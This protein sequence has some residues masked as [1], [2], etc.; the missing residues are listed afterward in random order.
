VSDSVIAVLEW[1]RGSMRVCVCVH[2]HNRVRVRVCE[3]E[4]GDSGLYQVC[5]DE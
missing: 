4:G 2:A 3:G 5:I 1:A